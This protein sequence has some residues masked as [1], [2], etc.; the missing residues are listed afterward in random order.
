LKL[1]CDES[2]SIVA[3]NFNLRRYSKVDDL[4][5]ILAQGLDPETADTHGNT[6]LSEAAAGGDRAT[7]GAY[8]RPPFSPT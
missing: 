2:L 7:A 5:R 4:Q 1:K 8:T 6:C 3:F